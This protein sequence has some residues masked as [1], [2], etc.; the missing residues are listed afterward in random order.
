MQVTEWPPHY[1]IKRHWRAKHVKITYTQSSG[2][3]ITLPKRFSTKHIPS[4]LEENK[5]WIL[6]QRVKQDRPDTRVRPSEV[7]FTAVN[8]RWTVHYFQTDRN[9]RVRQFG[10]D[11]VIL[12]GDIRDF[13]VCR[14]KLIDWI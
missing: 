11:G 2:L 10:C 4:I 3:E 7:Y 14:D 6:S 8:R 13:N 5:D 12:S 1:T 9:P